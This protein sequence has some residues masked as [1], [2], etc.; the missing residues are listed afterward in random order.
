[1]ASPEIGYLEG[2]VEELLPV[3]RDRLINPGVFD[4]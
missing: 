1:M 2:T 3:L 4:D